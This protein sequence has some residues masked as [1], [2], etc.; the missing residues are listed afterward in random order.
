MQRANAY[1]SFLSAVVA[2]T[3]RMPRGA[4]VWFGAAGALSAALDLAFWLHRPRLT[5][6]DYAGWALLAGASFLLT[7]GACMAMIGHRRSWA[8]LARFLATILVMIAPI[9][10]CLA[11]VVWAPGGS[12]RLAPALA[13]LLLGAV[14][15]TFLPGWPILQAASPRPVGLGAAFRSTKG[16]RR[17]LFVTAVVTS[18]INT[19]APRISTADTLAA[20]GVLA[21]L[22]GVITFFSLL[23]A[24]GIAVAAWRHMTAE[25][26]G[27]FQA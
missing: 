20:A 26:A 12:L 18:T 9:L 22:G 10:L 14:F 3:G 25:T 17:D 4:L 21:V 8:G 27:A 11:L 23:M 6:F 24:A 5:P 1:R 7:Y 16:L 19:A 2:E 15:L 13:A